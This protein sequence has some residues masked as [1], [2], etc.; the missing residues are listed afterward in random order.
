MDPVVL[1]IF[2]IGALIAGYIAFRL[3]SRS[4]PSP[5]D[6]GDDPTPTD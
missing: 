3:E 5:D 4:S 2:V 6:L 1:T